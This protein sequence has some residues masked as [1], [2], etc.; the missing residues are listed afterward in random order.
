MEARPSFE[1]N[2]KFSVPI[3]P[4]LYAFQFCEG[5][6]EKK[7]RNILLGFQKRYFRCLEGKVLIYLE[8]KENKQIK[9]Q[10]E[11]ALITNL[12][13]VDSRTFS[14]EYENVEY[15]LRAENEQIKKRWI[16]TL[17]YLLMENMKEK[18]SKDNNNIA[19]E[20][21]KTFSIDNGINKKIKVKNTLSIINRTTANLIKK[22][23]YI[24]NKEDPLSNQLLEAKGISKVI[25]VKDQ[26]I[27]IRMHYGIMYIKLNLNDSYNK[28]WFF[29]FSPRPLYNEY[30]N[31]YI[32]DL[33]QD[34]QKEWLKF[35]TLYYFKCDLIESDKF[36]YLGKI[37]LADSH[38]IIDFDNN[39][40][41]YI[42]LD[43]ND[44]VYNFF[45]ETKA[46]RDEWLEVI[47]NSHKTAKEYK[48]STTKH[49]RNVEI[50]YSIFI[51]D[52]K[53]NEFLNK[54]EE[55]KVR[56]IGNF[57]N[58]DEFNIF[59]FTINNF[60]Y[61]IESTIDGF[62]CSF[63]NKTDVVKLYADHMI[64]EY[65]EILKKYWN[66]QYKTLTND[67]II[68]LSYILLK[69]GDMLQKL[70]VDDQN[71]TK[72]GKELAKIY[73]NKN[74]QNLFDVI[75]NILRNE[76]QKK[77]IKN[78]QGQLF[79]QG[80]TDIFEI[81][82]YAF[83]SIK[84]LKHPIIYRKL[85][86]IYYIAITEYIVGVHC[87]VTNQDLIVE[88]EYLISVANSVFNL[89]QML[90]DL[91]DNMIKM[92]VL[93][94]KEIYEEVQ[95]KRVTKYINRLTLISINRFVFEKKEQIAKEFD[96][97]NFMDLQI[98][99][100]IIQ[101]SQSFNNNYKSIM[102]VP[103]I[104]R[105]WNEILKLTLCYYICSL[106]LIDDKYNINEIKSK[107]RSD[108]KLLFEAY[109]P[110]VGEHFTKATIKIL[111]DIIGFF[112]VSQPLIVSSCLTIRQFIGPAFT[113]SAAKKLIYLRDDF[114]YKEKEES[115]DE[116]EE[117]LSNYNGPKD[118]D[119]SGYF[120][121]LSERISKL[122]KIKNFIKKIS[123]DN[124]NIASLFENNVNLCGE[125]VNIGVEDFNNDKDNLY[126]IEEEKLNWA[127][128]N[129]DLG[130]FLKG[131]SDDED[132][133]D[134]KNDSKNDLGKN[135]NDKINEIN[136]KDNIN[137]I[138]I[139]EIEDLKETYNIDYQGFI[140]KKARTQLYYKYYFQLKNGFLYMYKDDS[141]DIVLNKFPL[142]NINEIE[143]YKNKKFKIK[144]TE[145][146]EGNENKKKYI[147]EY[148]FKCNSEQEKES[149][150]NVIAKVTNK[151]KKEKIIVK[152]KIEIKEYKKVIED[153]FNLPNIKVNEMYMQSKVLDSLE[154]E[155]YFKKNSYRIKIPRKLSKNKEEKGNNEKGNNEKRKNEKSKNEKSKNEKSKIEKGKNEIKQVGKKI[156][157]FFNYITQ[158]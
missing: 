135:K 152:E 70:N 82:N 52:K 20:S 71:V 143:N 48:L 158:K 87:V 89:I 145:N 36:D 4:V 93:S 88:H 24:F 133:I 129:S 42:N 56:T 68:Q 134:I 46:E 10:I 26:K 73:F 110:I 90:N 3:N 58:I 106:L 115:K 22:Y 17:S 84:K 141:S 157:N 78:A 75:E 149:W 2:R 12:K 66:K 95:M 11:I 123:D 7:A 130:D 49:P 151:Y 147:R 98:M 41:F 79:T 60:Q 64:V 47:K 139:E 21:N 150:M 122:E 101:T 103:I 127:V 99:E 33:E 37:D 94:E 1:I 27:Q 18:E 31:Y 153:F 23:G 29:I 116:C 50:L 108:Y 117:A 137:E 114:S 85:L 136:K 59:E 132:E 126:N 100:V 104:K 39:N 146:D 44:K 74:F 131:C 112:E 72:N 107:I 119:C 38:N 148:K 14:F 92:D 125:S 120:T 9:G 86:K 8:K 124:N 105:S 97:V 76:R 144:M 32:N 15:I 53:K 118:G 34:K 128:I 28:R 154:N 63:P 65:L 30:Y 19:S 62:L 121:I 113:I 13:S 111:N 35:D 156:K 5:Y 142:K 25:N 67:E 16:E 55:E 138:N 43:I 61:L 54:I 45:C 83:D 155:D 102:T 69:F 77:G 140:F 81:L 91:V 109:E 57:N 96:D 40:K 6:L 80:P 51:K